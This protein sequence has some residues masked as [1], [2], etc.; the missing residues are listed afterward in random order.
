MTDTV[1]ENVA[2]WMTNRFIKN[3]GWKLWPEDMRNGLCKDADEV[4]AIIL[5]EGLAVKPKAAIKMLGHNT[6][7]GWSLSADQEQILSDWQSA[8]ERRLGDEGFELICWYRW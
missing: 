6:V 5:K 7:S 2:I 1:R 8:I 3:E 4:I